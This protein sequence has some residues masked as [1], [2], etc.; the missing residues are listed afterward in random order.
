MTGTKKLYKICPFKN[1]FHT[2]LITNNFYITDADF[3]RVS[4]R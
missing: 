4:K 3:F 2:A 1:R